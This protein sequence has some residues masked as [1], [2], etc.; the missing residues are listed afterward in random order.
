MSAVFYTSALCKL[1]KRAKTLLN[2]KK[3]NCWIV[4]LD[5]DEGYKSLKEHLE[6]LGVTEE[7]STMPIL[8]HDEL[9]Y[10]GEDVIAAILAGEVK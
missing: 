3:I 6:D 9:V 8:I 10:S 7:Q 5:T 4:D 1:C 2:E